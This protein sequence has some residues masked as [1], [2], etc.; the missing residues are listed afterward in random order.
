MTVHFVSSSVACN[1]SDEVNIFINK[2]RLKLIS[3]LKY[4]KHHISK[5]QM[6]NPFFEIV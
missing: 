2:V 1:I 5:F 6:V 4:V 3:M